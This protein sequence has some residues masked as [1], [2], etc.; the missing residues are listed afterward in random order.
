MECG[1][2]AFA[3]NRAMRFR[4]QSANKHFLIRLPERC[5]SVDL[6][7]LPMS[8]ALTAH[9]WPNLRTSRAKLENLSCLQ[10]YLRG[11]EI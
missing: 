10:D 4:T 5:L 8:H 1:A 7:Y 9:Q 11:S 3:I 2:L 6:S